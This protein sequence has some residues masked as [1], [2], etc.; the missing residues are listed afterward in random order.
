MIQ[1]KEKSQKQ[2]RYPAG[3]IQVNCSGSDQSDSSGVYMHLEA[4]SKQH[5]GRADLLSDCMLGRASRHILVC[6]QSGKGH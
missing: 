1:F 6:P 3:C 2:V 5:Q 4:G